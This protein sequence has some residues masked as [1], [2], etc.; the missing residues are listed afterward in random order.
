MQECLQR[1]II[2]MLASGLAVS[3]AQAETLSELSPAAEIRAQINAKYTTVLS[4]ELAAKITELSVKEGE[5]FKKGQVLVA[6]NCDEQQ[7]QL[8][9]ARAVAQAAEK[10]YQV[11]SRLVKL[12]SIS[13]LDYELAAAEVAK[14]QADIAQFRA[15]LKKCKITAPYSGRVAERLVNRYQYVKAGDPLLDIVGDNQL[16]LA[17][18]VPSH[19]LNWLKPGLV[20]K[21][22]LE[23]NQ[24][25]YPAKV[26]QI[27]ARID[28]VSQSIKVI[29]EIDGEF[30]G[31]LPGMSGLALFSQVQSKH[32]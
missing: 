29:A 13:T 1:L 30:E 20:F 17:L 9:K 14:A 10:T 26:L 7:A 19:W 25:E 22:F 28:A 8:N 16:E 4:S 23:E 15:V 3:V 5:R 2:M 32:E 27:G 18:L 24:R 31:L 12:N 6:F 11:N 21:V